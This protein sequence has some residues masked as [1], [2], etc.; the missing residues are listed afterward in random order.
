MIFNFKC[1]INHSHELNWLNLNDEF[2]VW[3]AC[4]W[5]S[6]IKRKLHNRCEKWMQRLNSEINKKKQT[7]NQIPNGAVQQFTH[8]KME[9]LIVCGC[10]QTVFP[11]SPLH[12]NW[13]SQFLMNHV[14]TFNYSK[15]KLILLVVMVCWIHN[16]WW[17]VLLFV[18]CKFHVP[19][20]SL[21]PPSIHAIHFDNWFSYSFVRLRSF[22]EPHLNTKCI[23]F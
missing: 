11:F 9:I 3:L 23:R 6:A 4:C 2:H 21:A 5:T 17:G 19:F 20:L 10:S 16:N 13:R 1:E 8:L 18:R 14:S 15:K 22:F 7:W 12:L